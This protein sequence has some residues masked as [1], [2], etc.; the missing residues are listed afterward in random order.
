[1]ALVH[2]EAEVALETTLPGSRAELYSSKFVER[3]H[4]ELYLK[5]PANEQVTDDGTKLVPGALRRGRVTAGQHLAPVA[6]E[7]PELLAAWGERYSNL[8]GLELAVVGAICSH[9]R[10]LWIHPFPD[11]N[12]RAARLHTHLVLGSL[13]LT[14]GLWSPL[15]GMARNQEPAFSARTGGLRCLVVGYMPGS[16]ALHAGVADA[17][18][19]Q[20]SLAR[21][22]ALS[23]RTA[24]A[25]WGRKLGRQSGSVG[26]ASTVPTKFT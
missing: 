2:I 11:G 26:G 20:T 19:A 12:G 3:V 23:L 18:L 7:I 1:L 16:G 5:L 24:M 10:L 25:S 6:T 13:G 4:A 15:R 17:W 21:A 9:H 14:H 8:P 22:P